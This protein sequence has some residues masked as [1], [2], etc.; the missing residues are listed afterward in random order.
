LTFDIGDVGI[1]ECGSFHIDVFIPCDVT[2]AYNHCSSAHVYPD[3]PC[4]DPNP[5]WSG[6]SIVVR[7]ECE[8]N[9][10]VKFEI[11]NVGLAPMADALDFVIIEDEMILLNGNF[12]LEPSEIQPIDLP[13]TGATFIINAEQEPNHPGFSMPTTFVQGCGGFTNSF[14]VNWLPLDDANT[15]YDEDCTVNTDSYDPNE[16]LASPRGWGDA[17]LLEPNVDLEYQI[18]FQNEGNDTAFIV[19]V[20]DTLPA[21]LDFS[22]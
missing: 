17:H 21:T 9:E 16:K 5:N 19:V 20:L 1:G 15:F 13:A 2:F 3:A 18:N 11:E 4:G 22:L 8:D 12:D 14:I 7:G 6:A 10:L